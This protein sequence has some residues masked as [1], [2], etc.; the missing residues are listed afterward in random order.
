[1]VFWASYSR[2]KRFVP[3]EVLDFKSVTTLR[4]QKLNNRLQ[5]LKLIGLQN[6]IWLR[7]QNWI[8]LD[9]KTELT[10][11]QDWTDRLQNWIDLDY[12]TEL[13]RLQDW[14]DRLQNRI[15]LDCKTELT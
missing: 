14:T 5:I 13:T 7:L 10:R 15:D 8:D 3:C 9:Y 11:L 6:W 1:M 4:L 2:N 12:K